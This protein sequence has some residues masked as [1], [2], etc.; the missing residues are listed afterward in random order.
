MLHVNAFLLLA[1]EFSATLFADDTYLALY[2]KSLFT[3][4]SKV[5]A[6]HQNIIVT[7][8]KRSKLFL[9]YSKTTNLLGN[10]HS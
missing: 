1:S 3:L 6:Q 8:L 5:N 9:N 7:W 2:D 4:E 10:K